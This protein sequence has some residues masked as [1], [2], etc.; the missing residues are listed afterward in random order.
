MQGLK[1]AP[2][3]FKSIRLIAFISL[4][5]YGVISSMYYTVHLMNNSWSVAMKLWIINH[6]NLRARVEMCRAR[7]PDFSLA[8]NPDAL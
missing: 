6:Q 8:R 5:G 2:G 3:V 1:R 7:V 4:L